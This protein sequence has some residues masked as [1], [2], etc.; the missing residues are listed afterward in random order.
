MS[1]SELVSWWLDELAG[2]AAYEE[3]VTPLLV[4]VLEPDLK[5]TYLDLG[6][7]EGRV[8]RALE[9]LGSVCFGIE[10]SEQLARRSGGR[11]VV[12][13]LPVMPIADHSVD[14][15]LCVLVLEH[16]SDHLGFFTEAAR[17]TK[18]VGVLAIVMNHP[19]WTAPD[20][21]PITDADG[22][23]LWRPG[24]YFSEGTSEIPAGEDTV[25]FHHRSMG[26]LLNAAA[27]AG[28]ALQ[29]MIEQPHHDFEDQSGIP[30]LLACRWSLLL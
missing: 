5:K 22:E 29:R 17:I 8:M 25:T 9:A 27:D 20:S 18:P 15:A 13:K 4:D 23:T 26:E 21:T 14:G 28:W 16:L 12:A 3:V 11:T 24:D 30:R 10:A 7:G 1:W 2:D 6:S 19:V